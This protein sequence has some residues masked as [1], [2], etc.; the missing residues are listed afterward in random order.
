MFPEGEA[1]MLPFSGRSFTPPTVPLADFQRLTRVPILIFYGDNIPEQPST[2]PGQEQW[3]VFR[4]VAR[5]WRD[6]VN[7][8]GG[9]VTL[10]DLPAVGI[11]G[12]THFPMSDLNTG[13]VANE[14][15][16]GLS[17]KKLD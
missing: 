9:D 17:Q 5:L 4:E 14:M 6:T 15:A 2:N 8:H 7:H 16:R 10:V 13:D 3:R 11:R 12:N 1:P